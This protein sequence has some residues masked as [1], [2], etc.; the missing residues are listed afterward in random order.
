MSSCS[1]VHH[2]FTPNALKMVNL[3][4]NGWHECS[5]QSM[6]NIGNRNIFCI[7]KVGKFIADTWLFQNMAK[8][9]AGKGFLSLKMEW[10]C[11]FHQMFSQFTCF[12][13]KQII[14]CNVFFFKFKLEMNAI[15]PLSIYCSFI[16]IHWII[17]QFFTISHYQFILLKKL[18][19]LRE[20]ND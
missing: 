4:R 7:V 14:F 12:G 18:L 8:I 2:R 11:S 3:I 19:I 9:G 6:L 20:I 1:R 17:V 10:N 15:N 16:G 5:C 13:R